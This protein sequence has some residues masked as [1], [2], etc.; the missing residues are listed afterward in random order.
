MVGVRSLELL[1]LVVLPPSPL[2]ADPDQQ[3]KKCSCGG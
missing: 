1:V 3:S 2:V